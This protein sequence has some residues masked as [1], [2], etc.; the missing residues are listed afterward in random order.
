[1]KRYMI[2]SLPLLCFLACEDL[3]RLRAGAENE[4]IR[5]SIE[6]KGAQ[7]DA[8]AYEARCESKGANVNVTGVKVGLSARVKDGGKTVSRSFGEVTPLGSAVTVT[9]NRPLVIKGTV[10]KER[11]GL[12]LNQPKLTF[13]A[14][15]NYGDQ[16]PRK[17]MD[18]DAIKSEEANFRSKYE[19]LATAKL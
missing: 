17:N 1:M 3:S 16:D 12:M 9:P 19:I 14:N 15:L 10:P 2:L 6:S 7:G 11:M 5:C 8:Y 13:K 18:Y 4:A